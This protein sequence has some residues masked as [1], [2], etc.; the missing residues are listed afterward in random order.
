MAYITAQDLYDEGLEEADYPEAI[1]TARIK[2]AQRIIDRV[3]EKYFEAKSAAYQVD[4]SGFDFVQLPAPIISFSKVE[5][6]TSAGAWETQTL[7][8]FDSYTDNPEEQSRQTLFIIGS[9]SSDLDTLF[10]GIFPAG[11]RNIKITGSFGWIDEDGNVPEDIK[12]ACKLLTM[13]YIENIGSGEMQAELNAQGIKRLDVDEQ[14]IE[15]HAD[16]AMG[17]ITGNREVDLLLSGYT[18]G[19]YTGVV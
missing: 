8:N 11:R 2:L 14:E 17:N 7:A 13:Q 6:R 9:S 10:S 12:T 1:V 5:F 3:T 18:G 4:G 16:Y 15:T 19:F